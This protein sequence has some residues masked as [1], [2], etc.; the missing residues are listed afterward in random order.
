MQPPT[1]E[2]LP[3]PPP[4]KTGWPWTEKSPSLADCSFSAGAWPK[5][6]IVTPSHNQGQF[7][8]ET[9][10]SVLLQGYPDIEYII[11]DGGSNDQSVSIIK[12]Y[13]PWLAHWVS[14]KDEGQA[15]AINK[16]LALSSGTLLGYLNSDDLYCP[17]GLLRLLGKR[18]GAVQRRALLTAVVEDFHGP[19]LGKRH[20]NSRL[21]SVCEWLDGGIS[22]HQ[23][24]CL[25]TRDMWRECGPFREDLQYLFDRYFFALCRIKGARLTAEAVTLA[26]FRLHDDSKTTRF[27]LEHDRFSIEWDAVK[28]DLEDQLSCYQRAVLRFERGRRENWALV[29][30]ALSK[31]NGDEGAAPLLAKVCRDPIS[32]VH[33]PVGGALLRLA[34]R[35]A[36]TLGKNLVAALRRN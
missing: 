18:G 34:S 23:P 28:A 29:T 27:F 11:I 3:P 25:W 6:S 5:I 33:R 12:K 2:E 10:R 8:E 7:I 26:R 24:G 13:E 32:I 9:I 16:G 30:L 4:G 35:R 22:L 36:A 31:E 1:L 21:G 19:D 20:T 15:H 17:G 14:E